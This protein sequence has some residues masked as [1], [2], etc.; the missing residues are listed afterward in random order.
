MLIINLTAFFVTAY[1]KFAAIHHK[2]RVRESTL[3]I[4]SAT[5]GS[6]VMFLTMIIIRHKTRHH[7]FM[8]GIPIIIFIQLVLAYFIW[9]IING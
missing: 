3:L 7:K 1:D 5:G 6:I 4:I 2:W 9:R 8:V